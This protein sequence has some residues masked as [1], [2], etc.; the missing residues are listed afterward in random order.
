MLRQQKDN[1]NLIK[2]SFTSLMCF[3]RIAIPLLSKEFKMTGFLYRAVNRV[4]G[5]R[6]IFYHL[7]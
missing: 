1:H 4:S 5:K 3:P 6:A 7:I 2:M